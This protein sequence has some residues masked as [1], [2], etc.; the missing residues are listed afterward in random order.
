MSTYVITYAENY[1]RLMW[2]VIS[3]SRINIPAVKNQIGVIIKQ[4]VDGQTTL[5]TS[6]VLPYAIA[7]QE[8]SLV[9]YFGLQTAQGAPFILFSQLRP[10]FIQDS[11]S[12]Y[13]NIST[14]I[15][16]NN[17]QFDTLS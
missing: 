1:K 2:G 7:T 4:Y 16:S 15:T 17:W 14:F 8:G 9:G 3:D 5:V 13:Q 11:L 6:G 12:I 10:A